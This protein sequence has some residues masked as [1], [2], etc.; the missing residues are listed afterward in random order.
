VLVGVGDVTE[1]KQ[2]TIRW[3]SGIVSTLE[4]VKVDQTYPVV[5]PKD[6]VP[7][8]GAGSTAK[9]AASSSP[10][11][12]TKPVATSKTAEPA[13]PGSTKTTKP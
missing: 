3:P 10:A 9:P 5:E 11:D 8:R 7:D 13:P 6:G 1:L 12:P 4:K 2:I